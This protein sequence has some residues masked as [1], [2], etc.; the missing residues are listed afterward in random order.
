MAALEPGVIVDELGHGGGE[1]AVCARRGPQLLEAGEVV[2][3]CRVLQLLT[4]ESAARESEAELIHGFRRGRPGVFGDDA[5]AAGQGVADDAGGE[6]AAAAG[7]G[8]HGT[9]IIVQVGVSAENTLV[10]AEIAVEA[11]IELVSVAGV[12]AGAPVVIGGGL[13]GGGE[14]IGRGITRQ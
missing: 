6:S 3:L 7:Q 14:D 4:I 5:V 1:P 9:G 12:L 10:R 8:C 2:H 11:C 13:A